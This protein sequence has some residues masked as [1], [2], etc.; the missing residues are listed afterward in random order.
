MYICR[1]HIY[2]HTHVFVSMT[3]YDYVWLW[4]SKG[5]TWQRLEGKIEEGTVWYFQ[6]IKRK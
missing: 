6:K 2:V 5:G 3:I 4:E 1:D